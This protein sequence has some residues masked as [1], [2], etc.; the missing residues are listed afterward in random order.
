[1]NIAECILFYSRVLRGVKF[2]NVE[3]LAFAFST[4]H[5]QRAALQ[6]AKRYT[7]PSA[8]HRAA[9]HSAQHCT[10][11]SATL[12]PALHS[13]QHF[14]AFG[15]RGSKL[16]AGEAE[17]SGKRGYCAAFN[18]GL[19]VQQRLETL[20]KVCAPA[21]DFNTAHIQRAALHSARRYTAPSATLRLGWPPTAVCEFC[22]CTE[23]ASAD[24]IGKHFGR[25]LHTATVHWP[26]PTVKWNVLRSS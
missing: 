3:A 25:C 11:P 5:I 1:L 14:T 6:S 26:L 9:L 23:L 4:A 24:C 19:Q 16:S 8:A 22:R 20:L 7:A 18:E 13:A 17:R 10:A 12:H 2:Q 15:A 21:F